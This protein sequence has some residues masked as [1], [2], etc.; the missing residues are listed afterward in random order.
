VTPLSK[1]YT[2]N[3]P[4]LSHKTPGITLPAE[5]R[6][7]EFFLAWRRLIALMSFRQW[8]VTMNPGFVIDI[9]SSPSLSVLHGCF[10][11]CLPFDGEHFQRPPF[12]KLL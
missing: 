7:F 4:A 10:S 9:K 5:V 2:N 8:V 12:A 6:T 1:N 11:G 3:T